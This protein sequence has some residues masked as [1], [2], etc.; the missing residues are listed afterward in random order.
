MYNGA[1][2]PSQ[3]FYSQVGTFSCPVSSIGYCLEE[4]N[5]TKP[6]QNGHSCID[7][8]KILMTNGSLMKVKSIADAPLGAFCNT[9][10]LQLAIIGPENQIFGLFESGRFTQVLLYS[11]S[12]VSLKVATL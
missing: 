9:F 3:H 11:A 10:D 12:G 8:T 7:K 1:L 2:N 4:H 6:V 5:T